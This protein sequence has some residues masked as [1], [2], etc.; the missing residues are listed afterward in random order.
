MQ[1]LSDSEKA[2]MADRYNLSKLLVLYATRELA[3]RADAEHGEASIIIN[4]PNPSFCVSD[5]IREQ[6]D[7]IGIKIANKV[8]ARSTE[9]GSRALVH[10]IWGGKETHGEY[11]SNCKVAR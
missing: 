1:R 7:G 8:M 5:L 4:T 2:D 6:G 3:K 9:E 10:G 11:L